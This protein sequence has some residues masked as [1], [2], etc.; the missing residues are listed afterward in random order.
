[1]EDLDVFMENMKEL[2][3]LG[4][5]LVEEIEVFKDDKPTQDKVLKRA[6]KLTYLEVKNHGTI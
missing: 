6:Y 5:W 4:D 1:M 3:N 2:S